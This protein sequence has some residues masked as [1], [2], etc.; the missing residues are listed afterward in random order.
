MARREIDDEK[1]S[2]S[3]LFLLVVGLLLVGGVWAVWDDYVSRRPWKKYQA[4]FYQLAY[5]KAGEELNQEEQRLRADPAYQ[6]AQ[7]KLAAVQAQLRSG[8][9]AKRLAALTQK[10]GAAQVRADDLEIALRL[11]KSEIEAAWYEYDHALLLGHSTQEEKRTLDTLTT[12]A[13]D[14]DTRFRTAQAERDQIQKEIDELRL[15]GKEWEDKVKE[16]TAATERIKQRRDSYVLLSF[17]S[18]AIPKIP[19]IQQTVLEE[20][21]RGNFNTSLARVD[22]CQ[23]CHV[24]IDR[25]GFEDQP[26]PYKT[27]PYREVLLATHPLE[28]F[29]CTSCHEGQGAATSSVEKAHGEVEFWESP[30]RR[31]AKIEAN[32]IKCHADVQGLA[33]AQQIAQG[34]Y[35]FVQMGCHGCHVVEGYG[36]LPKIGPYLRRVVAKADPSWMVRWVTNPHAFRPH[37]RMPNFLLREDEALAITAYLLDSSKQEGE[38]WLETHPDIEGIAPGDGALVERGKT[39]V[40]SLGCRACHGF[41][42]EQTATVIGQHKD[43]APNLARIAEKVSGR[44]LYYWLKNPR[45]YSPTTAMPSLRLSDEEAKAIASYLMTLGEKTAKPEVVARLSDAEVVARGKGL[46]RKYGCYGCHNIPGMENEARIGVELTAFGSKTLEELFF[47]NHTDIPHTWDDWTYHKLAEPRIYATERIEQLMPQ[48]DF[49]DEDIKALRVFLTSRTDQR[50]PHQYLAAPG[51]RTQNLVAGQRLVQYYNCVGCHVIEGKGGY[52]RALYTDNP[53]FAPP[54]LNGEGVKVQ[55]EW[56]YGFVKKPISLRPWLQLRMPTFNLSDEEA[57][58][59]VDY[60]TALAKLA[61]PYVYVDRSKIPAEHIAAGKKLMSTDYFACF[62]CHQQG[63]QK[64]EGP[65]EGWAPDL[66]L[67]KQ[68]LDPEWIIRWI[69]D[70]QKLMPGTKMPSFYPGG[71]DDILEGNE[72]RQIEAIR[73][74]LMVLG[75]PEAQVASGT[76]ATAGTAGS[77]TN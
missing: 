54:I 4:T 59:I 7:A 60:F 20:F 12:E 5:D 26:N 65:P 51:T 39:L 57:R 27:H 13:N 2:Y 24:G 49:A 52:I 71:P 17:N 22:R 46:V 66:T 1:K 63:D 41:S 31:G 18:F 25:S 14:L 15:E 40:N 56:F 42:P 75:E 55:P 19:T 64:P 36:E 68:R 6:E 69:H 11:V 23:T 28:K 70:P 53:T 67:A 33:L 43:F 3:G 76:A 34:E 45:D 38:A 9:T 50:V 29:G 58:T 35:L 77:A 30:L 37:T 72:D 44:W 32:C 74:Y 16:L 62:S 61:V 8:E 48:F 10:L 21:D 47:G 73:D